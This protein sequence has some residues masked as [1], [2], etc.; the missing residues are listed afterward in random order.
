M[1]VGECAGVTIE[2][3]QRYAGNDQKE[4]NM[5]FQFEHTSLDYD[6][7]GKWTTK[8]FYLPDLKENL[9]K[10]QN[11]LSGKAWNSLY[12]DNHDQPRIVSRLGDDSPISAKCI[13][14]ILHMMQGTPYVYQGEELGMTNCKFGTIENCQDIEIINAYNDIVGGG[15]RT[16]EDF[17]RAVEAK[18]RDNARTPMQWNASE[19][20]GFT[21]G[22]PWLM[23]NPNYKEINAEAEVADSDSVFSYYKKLIKL[24]RDSEWS[25]V[26]VY[27]DY[28]LLDL[29]NEFV[30]TYL[31]KLNNKTLLVLCNVSNG[32]IEYQVPT[33]IHGDAT[34]LISNYENVK[35]QKDLKLPAWFSGVWEI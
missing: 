26:I 27:G 13:A 30:F 12:W 6:E 31:R 14:T 34:L 18:G 33:D 16:A 32:E 3:A 1:T 19:N 22:K 20:A 28:E 5:V 11:E 35:L 21:T 15:K 9:S 7:N 8:R 4:L 29:Q 17:M 2:Q 10:W 25:D 24:R 23:V